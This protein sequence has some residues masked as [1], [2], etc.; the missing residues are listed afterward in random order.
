MKKKAMEQVMAYLPKDRFE[1]VKEIFIIY[2]EPN[3]RRDIDN[4]MGF[5]AKV[6][7]DA[8]VK[9]GNLPDDGQKYVSSL[10]QSVDRGSAGNEINI[11][12]H[13]ESN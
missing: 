7:L 6:I 5:G 4:I 13:Y 9:N 8:L 11:G 1:N 2:T 3:R 12:V 10:T